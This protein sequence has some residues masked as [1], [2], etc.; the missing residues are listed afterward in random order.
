[1]NI[2]L[3]R[4][5]RKVKV[6]RYLKDALEGDY[7]DA[8]ND[9]HARRRPRPC[10][11][12]IHPATGCLY[13][14]LYCYVP[15][16]GFKN[17][18]PY[19]LTGLKLALALVSNPYIAPGPNGSFAAFGSVT[20]PLLKPIRGKT[21][22]YLDNIARF[23]S[24]SCQISTKEY[25][26][27]ELALELKKVERGLSILVTIVTI[28]RSDQ[29]EPAAPS[30]FQRFESISNLSSEGLHTVLFLRPA[31]PGV[32][33]REA[34]R[35]VSTALDRGAKGVIIGSLRVTSGIADR[36]KIAGVSIHVDRS[37][38]RKRSQTP[39][40]IDVKNRIMKIARELNARIYPSACS[41]NVDAHGEACT[42]CSYGPC[43]D[44]DRMPD[45]D[46][47]DVDEFLEE[48]GFNG[49]C[50][51]VDDRNIVL[52]VSRGKEM[53][54]WIRYFIEATTRRRVS[55]HRVG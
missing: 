29:L 40:G 50:L 38:L 24:L 28:D 33:E 42:A 7:S 25:V 26:S 17:F 3:E 10:G 18:K 20:E 2:L 43:G 16:M 5:E 54:D 49:R 21:L 31:I 1:V 46:C 48:I 36:L 47:S 35:I 37:R 15:D 32:S 19:P 53:L 41:A 30:P 51:N 6:Q 12:T 14:C 22:E 8:L 34:H 9:Y 45:V 44:L 11:I 13:K 55:I 27:R 23:L 4:F 52:G 39:V